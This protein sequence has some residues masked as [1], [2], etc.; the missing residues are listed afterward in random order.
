MTKSCT[1]LEIDAAM[2]SR[3]SPL[4]LPDTWNLL[5]ER[6]EEDVQPCTKTYQFSFRAAVPAPEGEDLLRTTSSEV[7]EWPRLA[8]PEGCRDIRPY[9]CDGR[10]L[11]ESGTSLDRTEETSHQLR[12]RRPRRYDSDCPLPRHRR[13][14]APIDGETAGHKAELRRSC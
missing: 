2:S 7:F 12:H 14:Q 13:P 6:G 4:G 5:R 1:E 3:S 8:R 9:L 11:D 10:W